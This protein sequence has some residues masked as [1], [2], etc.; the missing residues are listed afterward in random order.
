M[1]TT[2]KGHVPCSKIL[3]LALAIGGCA[4]P[5][6]TASA[7]YNPDP[8]DDCPAGEIVAV[9]DEPMSCDLVG[10]VNTLTLSFPSFDG[11]DHQLVRE[12]ADHAGCGPIEV[13]DGVAHAVDCDF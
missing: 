2:R 8:S 13:R 10:G 11:Y 1:H 12:L 9:D 7:P 6:V 3:T 4:A 5:A